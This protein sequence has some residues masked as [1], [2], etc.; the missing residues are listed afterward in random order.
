MCFF[1][2]NSKRIGNRKN[3]MFFCKKKKPVMS[4][5]FCKERNNEQ[6]VFSKNKISTLLLLFF[7][8]FFF[9]KSD[10]NFIRTRKKHKILFNFWLAEKKYIDF[11]NKRKKET[12]KE[13]KAKIGE[14][15]CQNKDEQE[16]VSRRGQTN[17][18]RSFYGK[19]QILRNGQFLFIFGS[20]CRERINK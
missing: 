18:G 8:F 9:L 13:R 11:Y 2:Y 1:L 20:L 15:A 6:R 19:K 16:I 7:F 4:F 3:G 5:Y 14:T 12:K 17:T 10:T